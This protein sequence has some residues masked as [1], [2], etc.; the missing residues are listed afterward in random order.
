MKT[1]KKV[2]SFFLT[3]CMLITML[4]VSM[5]TAFA[6][7]I[8]VKTLDGTTIAIEVE[9]N[10]SIDHIKSQ[11]YERTGVHPVHQRLSFAGKQIEEGKTLS[12]YNIQKESTIHLVINK[13]GYTNGICAACD[14]F[15]P[16]TDVDNDGVYEISN[17]GQLYWFAE[18][19]NAGN[20]SANAILTA[21]ITV[22]EDVLDE[23][24]DVNGAEFREWIPIG[25][26]HGTDPIDNTKY[27]E[28]V[29]DGNDYTVSGLYQKNSNTGWTGFFG[30]NKGTIKNFELV[31]SYFGS[32]Q[33]NVGIASSVVYN[34]NGTVYNVKSYATVIG[35]GD[36]GGI[37]GE[38]KV[39]MRNSAFLGKVVSSGQCGA[40]TRYN[41]GLIENCYSAGTVFSENGS[42]VA[43]FA[44]INSRNGQIKNCF[45]YIENDYGFVA[46]NNGAIDS[47]ENSYYLADTDD[48]NGGKTAE[49]F[50]SGEVAY[51]LQ[52][53]QTEEIWGQTI[54]TDDYPVLGGDKVYEV[55]D[56]EDNTLYSNKNENGQHNVVNGYCTNC[57][58]SSSL[59][60]EMRLLEL[61]IERQYKKADENNVLE[62]KKSLLDNAYQELMKVGKE[63]ETGSVT[64]LELVQMFL[65][66]YK[67]NME[68]GIADGTWVKADYTEIDAAVAEIE[69]SGATTDKVTAKLEEIKSEISVMKDDSETTK[70]DVA[71]L[72]KEVEALKECAGGNH[73]FENDNCTICGE[74]FV[75]KLM[76]YTITLGDKV[77]VNYFMRLTEKTLSDAN[78][79]MVFTVPD[80]GSAYTVEIPVSKAVKNGD[81]YVFTC[82]VA[83]KEMTSAI[84][85]KLVT[86]E[87]ELV[88]E[89]YTVKDYAEYI[90]ANPETYAK[91]QKL[92]RAMLNYG[93]E[94][95]I[96]F[97]YN[98]D[99]LANDTKYMSDDE[100]K[101]ELYD[102][103][104]TTF[105]LEGSE[106]GVTYYGTAL[107]LETELMFKHYFI[108]DEGVDVQ[109]L[110]ISCEYP[111][112]FNKNGNLYE[113]IIS[114]IPAHKMGES[115]IVVTIG[116]ITL[117]YTIRS[118]GAIVQNSARTELWTIVSALT[119]YANTAFEY[120]YK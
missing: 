42:D 70:A 76:G 5:V 16:A 14:A 55:K 15:E 118:Y 40:I 108:V 88:L 53:E 98:T 81:Y 11:V 2:I 57:K 110:E 97:N 36:V 94:A 64:R 49:Q 24:G 48:G 116:G 30:E 47:I 7:Q 65:A 35:K 113:L 119:H 96:Y 101:T 106:T 73:I 50:A 75:D 59:I 114:E 31:D 92:V 27:F 52:G 21:D 63:P 45:S 29:F 82:E 90:L 86:S 13:C 23:N 9:P 8:F 46:V 100:K 78:A 72:M 34:N 12:D 66:S 32:T 61:A 39:T 103:A 22:N 6:M 58:R 41:N 28:G 17:A 74:E 37:A 120:A 18:F 4:S 80:T 84:S 20:T 67:K 26:M 19:V 83:A 105:T 10:D 60:S 62:S 71:V 107:S 85:A 111:V 44:A 25:D 38:T 87:T 77:A 79:K 109:S 54:G 104:D 95:Q 91:E 69:S 43:N 33:P 1:T 68:N 112:A 89:D 117:D 93:A 115:S 56:C 3:V 51:L 99:N 102:F